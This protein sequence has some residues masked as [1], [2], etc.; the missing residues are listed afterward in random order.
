MKKSKSSSPEKL[1][2]KLVERNRRIHMKGLCFKLTSLIP[3]HHFRPSKDMLS[4]QD[5]LD[6]AAE[7]IKQLKERIEELKARRTL[8]MANTNETNKN[9]KDTMMF[10]LRLPVVE[11]KDLGSSLEVVL[12][13]G[14]EKNFML[15]EVISVLEDE[16]AEVV[17][18]SVSTMGDRVFHTLHAQVKV[19][20]VGVETS[21]VCQRLHELVC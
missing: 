18:T 4:Q 19:T 13:S 10:G 14:L 9:I 8:A 20:R 11:L 15:Y 16:G 21:R 17:S 12:I 7:Y 3:P 1:D 2:R 6:Q 5:Q